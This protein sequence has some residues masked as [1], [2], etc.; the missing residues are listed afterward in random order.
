MSTYSGAQTAAGGG[1]AS[2]SLRF[3][4]LPASLAELRALSE[5]ALTEPQHAAA[6]AVAAL[7][8]YCADPAA[9][10]AML[11]FLKGPT[12]LSPYEV[13]FL[14]DRMRGKEY[15]P[16]SYFAGAKPENSYTPDR[17]YTICVFETP[18]SRAQLAEGYLQLYVRSGGADA[19]RPVKLRRR[20]SSGQWLLWEQILLGDIRPPASA[21]PWS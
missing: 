2:W 11:N 18:H 4:V 19:P 9:S 14:A 10:I 15:L 21:D 6:L 13:Q 7:C 17:P 3:D 5:S 1:S 16:L 12:P 8:A 20:Q